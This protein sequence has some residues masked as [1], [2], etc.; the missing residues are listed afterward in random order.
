MDDEQKEKLAA[1]QQKAEHLRRFIK[2]GDVLTHTRCMGCLEEHAFIGWDGIWLV[3]I[4]TKDTMKFGDLDG[5]DTDH[6]VNDISPG[7]VTHINRVPIE[8]VE[9]L[10][11]CEQRQAG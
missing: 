6:V 11:S 10:A 4:P 3:G 2:Q 8:S 9:F 1:I 7:N 5:R